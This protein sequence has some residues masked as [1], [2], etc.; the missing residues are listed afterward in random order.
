MHPSFKI[1]QPTEETSVIMEYLREQFDIENTEL[2]VYD[3]LIKDFKTK[4]EI[5]NKVVYIFKYMNV[6]KINGTGLETGTIRFA[7]TNNGISLYPFVNNQT[8]ISSTTPI[9][10]YFCCF[11]GTG[12][13]KLATPTSFE[14]QMK[15]Y[16][17]GYKVKLVNPCNFV[18]ADHV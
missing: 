3:D 2:F 17:V 16:A 13:S 1:I 15:M 12:V 8:F 5:S 6:M 7:F 9:Y 11:V 4:N 18:V 10:N 14:N